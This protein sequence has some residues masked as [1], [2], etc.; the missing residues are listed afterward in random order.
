V[1]YSS[2]HRTRG[3]ASPLELLN[4]SVATAQKQLTEVQEQLTNA[5]ETVEKLKIGF[6]APS[7]NIELM[8][9]KNM[10]VARDS[11]IN[12]LINN[13][14]SNFALHW[15]DR[16]AFRLKQR[17]ARSMQQSFHVPSANWNCVDSNW[18][19]LKSATV[20]I[21]VPD[22]VQAGEL[23]C[24]NCSCKQ[25]SA[26]PDAVSTRSNKR[27]KINAGEQPTAPQKRVHNLLPAH[28]SHDLR[29]LRTRQGRYYAVLVYAIQ[30][31][32]E[33]PASAKGH[34]GII[35]PGVGT[36]A[37]VYCPRSGVVLKLGHGAAAKLSWMQRR[38]DQLRCRADPR[39]SEALAEFGIGTNHRQRC[40]LKR[41]ADKLQERIV[42]LVDDAHHHLANFLCDHF[43]VVLIP[44]FGTSQMVRRVG[45]RI[46][47]KT[48]RQLQ[49]WAHYRFLQCLLY[50]A[51]RRGTTVTIVSEAYTTKSCP[52]CGTLN[53]KVGGAKVFR[54][55]NCQHAADR[56]THGAM[57]ILLRFLTENL[58]QAVAD[59]VFNQARPC[60]PRSC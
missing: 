24:D 46:G 17:T 41:A 37:T 33:P 22:Y 54:C 10:G 11:A 38:L 36:A 49:T 14:R 23:V 59:V 13:Y 35:D 29:F 2:L 21:R 34:I 51:K 39:N 56:D 3:I 58:P 48:A 31:A 12:D 45:R 40:H 5:L 19:P 20:H 15:H 50:T 16:R 43:E 30:V 7:L 9:E 18:Q 25:P 27:R 32:A 42:R 1:F 6:V 53:Q 47:R 4:R 57:N 8:F 28:V 60:G 44:R 26:P 52:C 55:P